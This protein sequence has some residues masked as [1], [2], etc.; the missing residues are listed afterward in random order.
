MPEPSLS[1]DDLSTRLHALA[2]AAAG[3]AHDGGAVRA[4]A[5][6]RHR[7][8][9]ATTSAAGVLVVVALG[10]TALGLRDAGDARLTVPAAPAPTSSVSAGPAPGETPAASPTPTPAVSPTGSA[11]PP[12][13][14]ASPVEP[15]LLDLA[16]A[17]RAEPGD[18]TTTTPV[19]PPLLDPCP[20][21]TTY[22]RD[23]D[24]TDRAGV[25]LQALREAGG[26]GVA[27][28]V[29][30][31]VDDAAAADATDG[32][33]RAVRGCPGDLTGSSGAR[34]EVLQDSRSDERVRTV[35][36]RR[37]AGCEVCYASYVAVQQSRDLV[38]VLLVEHGED[39][40]PGVSSIQRYLPAVQARL[41]R[42]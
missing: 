13:R 6:R 4:A 42:G 2:A 26:T 22:P 36:V 34:Y 12:A 32:Y 8:R 37:A 28:T 41:A 14:S 23:A 35:L 31:Y 5:A 39:G 11:T 7:R 27:Q 30:R 1:S 33:V 9:V 16:A 38:S 29:A 25:A 17:Q 21:G 18:W 19:P 24:I 3:P 40:D 15:V 10:G 20:G